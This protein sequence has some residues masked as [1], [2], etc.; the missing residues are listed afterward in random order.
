MPPITTPPTTGPAGP[1]DGRPPAAVYDLRGRAVRSA[2]QATRSLIHD[3]ERFVIQANR[4]MRLHRDAHAYYLRLLAHHGNDIERPKWLT[5]WMNLGVKLVMVLAE[6]A[7]GAGA[8]YVAGDPLWSALLTFTGVGI[9]TV[10][11]GTHIGIQFR[12]AEEGSS[13]SLVV[14]AGLAVLIAAL[15]LGITRYLAVG[16][17][18]FWL[19][20]LTA[21]IAIGSAI[22]SY[23]WHDPV[24]D[25]LGRAFDEQRSLRRRAD[26]L[27]RH[28]RVRAFEKAEAQL[29]SAVFEGLQADR[30]RRAVPQP[31]IG[32][33]S[34]L[35]ALPSGQRATVADPGQTTIPIPGATV[36]SVL[37]DL[38]GDP[39]LDLTAKDPEQRVGGI[40][41][42]TQP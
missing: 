1:P 9:T 33:G 4:L 36:E 10:A 11:A 23:L 21:V 18:A 7:V 32:D 3:R 28:R 27:Y 29:R 42:G 38:V 22:L 5:T 41:D 16:S 17:A 31:A 14:L 37:L 6:I 39:I 2:A 30:R 8:L 24:A 34:A 12:R 20:G 35:P 40:L 25:R 15:V 19:G 13:M 26:K